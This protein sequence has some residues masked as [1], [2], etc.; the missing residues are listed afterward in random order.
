MA[1][2]KAIDLL[3]IAKKN[4]ESGEKY[5]KDGYV[6]RVVQWVYERS[7]GGTG[8]V[9]KLE[10]RKLY[11]GEDGQAKPGKADGFSL[12]DITA[13]KP[14]WPAIIELL[15]NPPPPPVPLQSPPETKPDQLEDVPF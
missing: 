7:K 15:K 4:P 13:L 9:V 11:L 6:L 14:H 8:S 2:I 1:D 12:A 3:V 5:N 10:R